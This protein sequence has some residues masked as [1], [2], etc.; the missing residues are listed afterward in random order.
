[1][2][3][4]AEVQNRWQALPRREQRLLWLALAVVG[5]AMLW[6]LALA[7]ALKVLNTAPAQHAQL[8]AQW[9]HMQQLQAQAQALR[10]QPVV[11]AAQARTA[12][13]DSVS[14]LGANAKLVV[15]AE[16]VT[17]TLQNTAPQDLAQ[18]LANARQNA[19]MAP[20]EARLTRNATGGWDGTLVLHLP[21]Q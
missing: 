13:D 8:D 17:L 2:S 1:M 18:W 4:W 21:A 14:L 10:A 11:N 3:A 5:L 9:Q 16:R 12:L 15:Q 7:P 20:L 6:W 19:H